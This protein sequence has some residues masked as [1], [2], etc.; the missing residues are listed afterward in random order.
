MLASSYPEWLFLTCFS[1]G[2]IFRDKMIVINLL[3]A[4]LKEANVRNK[5]GLQLDSSQSQYTIYGWSLLLL[6]SVGWNSF[7]IFTCRFRCVDPL[8]FLPLDFCPI[9]TGTLQHSEYSHLDWF[10]RIKLSSISQLD[11]SNTLYN[12]K[13]G[14]YLVINHYVCKNNDIISVYIRHE[15]ACYVLKMV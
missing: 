7:W 4:C 13:R 14:K 12:T 11:S 6:A 2:T 15:N 3:N 1:K 5:L 9:G 10:L 8:F